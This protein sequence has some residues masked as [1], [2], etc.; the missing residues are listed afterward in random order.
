MADER[1]EVEWIATANKMVQV[2]DRLEGKFDKQERQLEKLTT[3]SK[4]NAEAAAGSFNALEQELK[5]AEAALKG[6]AAGTDAFAAQKKKVDA[7]RDSLKQAKGSIQGAAG[8]FGTKLSEG[9]G[10]IKNMVAGMFTLQA[11]VTAISSELEK[12]S[13]L[14]LEAAQQTRTFEDAIRRMTLNVGAENAPRA[15]QM[16][17]QQA[18]LL[19]V[20]PSG[21]AEM[22][23]AAISGGAKDID[24]AMRLSSDVLKLT[25]GNVQDA[26]PILSG[27]LTIAGAT[28]NRDFQAIIGQLSQFQAAGRGG[29]LAQTINN[30]STSLAAVNTRGERIQAL[31]SERTLEL[32]ATISQ[33]LQDE[34]GA[35]TGTTLRQLMQRM[36]MFVAKPE[37][38]LD[39]G[40][41][42]RL[43]QAQVEGFN[44]L[45]TLD[46]RIEAM[47]ATPELAKQFLS[48]LEMN[49]G[50]AAIRQIV[51]GDV[52]AI[53]EEQKAAQLI[54]GQAAGKQE[55]NALTT[56]I[57]NQT[58]L[59]RAEAKSQAALAV[60]QAT[61]ERGVAGQVE[62]IVN[63]TLSKINLSGIDVETESVIRNRMRLAE[64]QGM[65]APE[66]GIAGLQ[67]AMG[68][69]RLFGAIPV[70]GQLSEQDRAIVEQ[71]IE[72]LTQI[73]DE[74][75]AARQQPVK[76]QAPP[77]RPKEAPLPA[78]TAP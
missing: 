45:G 1:I 72:L 4:K 57:A 27:M 42:S 49:E 73:R 55:F 12:V 59:S 16:V 48:T 14:R 33:I 13:Q 76:V 36:D 47:R 69:R 51:T 17:L 56:E 37:T 46:A 35:I 23:G 3:T 71:Q 18:P 60:S 43:T 11:V 7:L 64:L 26:M 10:Q 54:G 20:D 58:K 40:T 30:L 15:Q 50:T 78:A 70:G 68:R 2:L 65:S 74:M 66:V 21:L 9:V 38:K 28:N 44:K 8:G 5:Q 32:A 63:D 77:M 22:I 75:A 25:A 24:E 52:S 61:G 29:D 39:D 34:R 31:G 53:A 6:M 67:E 19:G 62:K 41:V